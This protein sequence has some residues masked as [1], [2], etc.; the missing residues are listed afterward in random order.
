MYTNH[1]HYILIIFAIITLAVS[2]FGFVFLRDLIY[3]RAVTSAKIA[4][5]VSQIDEQNKH[6]SDIT[7]IY[8]KSSEQRRLLDSFIVPK[9]KIVDLIESIEKIGVD[10]STDLELSSIT[11]QESKDDKTSQFQ[12]HVDVK[13]TWTNIM[14]SLILIEGLPYSVSINNTRLIKSGDSKSSQWELSL[15]LRVLT[16]K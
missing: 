1:R 10:T 6:E 14:R 2:V 15:D 13:G 4:R 3:S 16:G 8:D 9:E 11:N 5:E 7:S 12:A